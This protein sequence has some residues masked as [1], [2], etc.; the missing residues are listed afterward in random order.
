MRIIFL[1]V[2]GV[3]NNSTTTDRIWGS[4]LLTG[5]QDNLLNNLLILHSI[6]NNIEETNIV[7][8]SSWKH[9]KGWDDLSPYSY[10]VKRFK[11][12]GLKLYDMTEDYKFSSDTK[13]SN[14]HADNILK[15]GYSFRGLS[16]I[17]WLENNKDKDISS[18]VILDDEKSLI[19]DVCAKT[20]RNTNITD[21]L[22]VTDE[23]YGLTEKDVDKALK[24]LNETRTIYDF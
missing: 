3:L 9:T 13:D 17:L 16:I 8:T 14:T 23:T 1:D 21:H 24:I 18:F 4:K 22:I 12:I 11:E 7:L 2:D 15:S 5:I 20:I 10:L 19:L 6:S